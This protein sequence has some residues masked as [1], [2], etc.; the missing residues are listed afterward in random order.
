MIRKEDWDRIRPWVIYAVICCLLGLIIVKFDF[1]AAF[2]KKI[3][4]LFT[5]LIYGLITAFILNIPMKQIEKLIIKYFPRLE[6]KKTL[7]FLSIFLSVILVLAIIVGIVVLLAPQIYESISGL[8]SNMSMILSNIES[9]INELLIDLNI[10]YQVKFDTIFTIPWRDFFN[11]IET[12]FNTYVN[13]ILKNAKAF[14]GTMGNV[15]LGFMMSFYL[16]SGKE[17]FILGSKKLLYALLGSNLSKRVLRVT[18]LANNI[19]EH[20]ISGQLIEMFI[21][22][23]IFYI[24][25]SIFRM[26]YAILISL[27]TGISGIIPII[28]A[29]M[30]MIFGAILILGYTM[31]IVQVIIFIVLYQCLQQFENNVIYPRVVGSSVG[32]PGI[33]VLLAIV[34]F[35]DLFG[36]IGMIVAVPSMAVIYALITEFV[37]H[38]VEKLTEFKDET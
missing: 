26:P 34:I 17:S 4:K 29:V 19:F 12:Y 8:I 30:A 14:S 21:L 7:R 32:L 20:F 36:A 31:S 13:Q 15:F 28:G 9:Y 38:R 2:I 23:G 24:G 25:L 33:F 5:P 1:I 37:D 22:A 10:D 6:G 3:L 18:D 35:G 16:L 27:L 11:N